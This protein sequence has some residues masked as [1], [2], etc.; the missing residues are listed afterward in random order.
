MVLLSMDENVH[1]AITRGVRR[2]GVDV[3]TV[4]DDG[5]GGRDDPDVVDRATALG[6]VLFSQDEDLLA[7]ATHRQ[8]NGIAFA[9]VVFAA[10]DE[11]A[12]GQCVRDLELI[13][14]AGTPEEFLDRVH[15]LPL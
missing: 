15:Y 12:I 10:Q 5:Y 9:G 6:R 11:V 4:Q 8:R 13:A 7:E 2:R 14:I 1:G 3:V